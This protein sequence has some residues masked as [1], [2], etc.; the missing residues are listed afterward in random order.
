MKPHESSSAIPP[1]EVV[2]FPEGA[3]RTVQTSASPPTHVWAACAVRLLL[4]VQLLQ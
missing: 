3:D 4:F 1:V 2:L